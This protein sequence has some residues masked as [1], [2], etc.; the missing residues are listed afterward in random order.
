MKVVTNQTSFTVSW[1]VCSYRVNFFVSVTNSK[2]HNQTLSHTP[3]HIYLLPRYLHR[4]MQLHS[5]LI[6][7]F[8]CTFLLICLVVFFLQVFVKTCRMQS[9]D[10]DL[11]ICAMYPAYQSLLDFINLTVSSDEYSCL[12]T[13]DYTNTSV[14]PI[15]RLS[16]FGPN[17]YN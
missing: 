2:V 15:M 1:Q 5:D 3:I 10:L 11:L 6:L 14:I 4:N 12:L 9:A 16:L 8:P 17:I 7:T 13:Y